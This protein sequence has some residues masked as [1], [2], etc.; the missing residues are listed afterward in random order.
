MKNKSLI[1]LSIKLIALLLILSSC[2]DDM[3]YWDNYIYTCTVPKGYET[4][5]YGIT[6]DNFILHTGDV[7]YDVM[8]KG[9]GYE[10]CQRRPFME[11]GKDSNGFLKNTSFYHD[12]DTAINYVDKDHTRKEVE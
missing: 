4:E 12:K 9:Q 11:N 8:T 10:P 5:P 1:G 2:T 6:Y 7:Y 3:R